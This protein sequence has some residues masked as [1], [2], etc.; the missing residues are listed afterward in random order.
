MRVLS[1]ILLILALGAV[2][3]GKGKGKSFN[4]K[5]ARSVLTELAKAENCVEASVPKPCETKVDTEEE[6]IEE[7]TPTL[8]SLLRR[9]L[10]SSESESDSKD[11]E[12]DHKEERKARMEQH[13]LRMFSQFLP[14]GV[15]PETA[16]TEEEEIEAHVD[17]LMVA[18]EAAMTVKSFESCRDVAREQKVAGILAELCGETVVANRRTLKREGKTEADM[19]EFKQKI[20]TFLS[21]KSLSPCD[22]TPEELR[23]LM[24][25]QREAEGKA[26]KVEKLTALLA[27]LCAATGVR[28]N[29]RRDNQKMKEY[30]E[31]AGV[32][33]CT[34]TAEEAMEAL[35]TQK[36]TLR[37][38]MEEKRGRGKGG[39]K[40]K[41][42]M[43]QMMNKFR[44]GAKNKRSQ[45]SGSSQGNDASGSSQGSK[46]R[47]KKG[48][49]RGSKKGRSKGSSGGNKGAR[50]S[51]GRGGWGRL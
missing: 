28:R 49:S 46:G 1:I 15:C 16:L 4:P 42:D 34:S 22:T 33:P 3:H 14:N 40:R 30:L 25:E 2:A 48:S 29:L 7:E 45:G 21:E 50:K 8:E 32:D 26:K 37:E 20:E 12:E 43:E 47:S 44:Q 24:K 11:S 17:T 39:S 51:K 35:K 10:A 6:T 31:K 36:E 13:Y 23:N 5:A 9:N 19:E 41:R 27:E 18:L 38:G